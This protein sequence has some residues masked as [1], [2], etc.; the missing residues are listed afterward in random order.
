MLILHVVAPAEIGGLERVVQMLAHGQA[1]A[2]DD[3]HVA[4]VL[5]P[6]CA[7]HPL[8]ET[9]ATGGVAPHPIVLPLR[10]YRRER[11]A[12]RQ[13]CRRLRPDVVHTHGYRPDIVDAVTARREEI[14]TVTTV[15]GF[16]GGDWK[17]RMYERLQ[18]RA[19]RRF[20]AVVAVSR[21]LAEQL[22]GDD[23][24]P[25]RVHYVP[26]AWPETVPPLD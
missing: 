15:H 7:N 3:V 14:P 18:R 4:M 2:G 21:P 17:N 22:M 6:A 25:Q 8:R 10:S 19:Y 20:D 24:P 9:L 12:L 13:L 23:V 26:N 16:T 11:A 1:R 5:D